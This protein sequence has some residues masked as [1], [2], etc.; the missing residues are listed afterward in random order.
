[1]C[2]PVGEMNHIKHV[3]MKSDRLYVIPTR[4]VSAIQPFSGKNKKAFVY[5]YANDKV[6][7]MVT[8][9]KSISIKAGT[10]R[11][12]VCYVVYLKGDEN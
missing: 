7:I 5:D 10:A 4:T 11:P 9:N 3:R 8:K 6:I 1:M 2:Q 12:T